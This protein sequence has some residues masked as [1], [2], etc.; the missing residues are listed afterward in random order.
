MNRLRIAVPV[1]VLL[2]G[3][4]TVGLPVAEAIPREPITVKVCWTSNPLI[5][6]YALVD[7]T[8][9]TSV[10]ASQL[11][12]GVLLVAQYDGFVEYGYWTSREGYFVLGWGWESEGQQFYSANEQGLLTTE[13][14]AE[15]MT[16]FG[17]MLQTNCVEQL[18]A[19]SIT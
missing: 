11:T 1:I 18:R 17:P 10:T 15:V 3:L 16:V 4:I 14:L 12:G 13:Q 19:R 7:L 9:G 8:N 6:Q 5:S 2:V